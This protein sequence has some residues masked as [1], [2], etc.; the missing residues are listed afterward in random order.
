MNKRREVITPWIWRNLVVLSISICSTASLFRLINCRRNDIH[1]FGYCSV[2]C[3]ELADTLFTIA[4]NSGAGCGIRTRAQ[5]PAFRFSGPAPSASWVIPHIFGVAWRSR[6]T[7]D[8]SAW[9]PASNRTHFRSGNASFGAGRRCRP[10][11]LVSHPQLS[12]LVSEPSNIIRHNCHR[13]MDLN[14][15]LLSRNQVCCHYTNPV[16]LVRKEGFN[17]LRSMSSGFWDRRVY[18][19]RH[20]RIWYPCRGSNPDAS[21]QPILSR[22]CLPVSPHGHIGD[23]YQ[24]RTDI[25]GLRIP[26]SV[27]LDERAVLQNDTKKL[28]VFGSGSWI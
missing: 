5:F 20:L 12:K 11:W 8:I 4:A 26:P 18:L 10:P 15:G 25:S 28:L 27:F 17:P 24:T 6:T 14:H 21:R 23:P 13:I 19:F 1:Q 2:F 16:C 9:L 3:F 7:S 22:L